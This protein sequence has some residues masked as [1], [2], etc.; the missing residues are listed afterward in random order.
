[1][2]ELLD[3]LA[4]I[5]GIDFNTFLRGLLSALAMFVVL[6]GG[7]YLI[8]ATNL[9]VRQGLYLSLA[10]LFGWMFLMGIVWTIY[11]KGWVGGTPTWDLVEIN[12]GELAIAETPEAQSLNGINLQG[13]PQSVSP[14]E[15][16]RGLSEVRNTLDSVEWKYLSPSNSVRGEAQSS[17]DQYLIETATFESGE[18][19]PLSFGAFSTGGKPL[20]T[21]DANLFQRTMHFFSETFA[22]PTHS[23][24]LIA[25]QVQG[26][27]PKVASLGEPPP[28]PEIDEEKPL[29]TVVMERNRGGPFPSVISD[30]RYIPLRFTI[31]TGLIFAILVMI[32]HIRD[33]AL[34]EA[35]NSK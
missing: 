32:L 14:F 13:V 23:Q 28:V 25:V 17:V 8:V 18:Y 29:V 27:Q 3:T 35:V 7:T 26:I 22:H 34:R 2:I 31:I 33:L 20:L 6:C 5:D 11:G 12:S 24:E 9:G 21:H 30:L 15:T 10:G 19:V 1:M 4:F 16:F